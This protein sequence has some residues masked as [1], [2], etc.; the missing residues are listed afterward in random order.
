ML[1]SIVFAAA[2]WRALYSRRRHGSQLALDQDFHDARVGDPTH[3][4]R[5]G[6][7]IFGGSRY[8]LR[9]AELLISVRVLAADPDGQPGVPAAI[10]AVAP[11]L[12]AHGAVACITSLGVGP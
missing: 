5:H 6:R 12:L 9:Q 3:L 2:S 7:A 1:L 10:A 8:R 11:L 4:L